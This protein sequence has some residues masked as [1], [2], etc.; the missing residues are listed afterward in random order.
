MTRLSSHASRWL[1]AAIA[2]P[3]VLWVLFW[4]PPLYFFLLVGLIGLG[5]WWEF[6]SVCFGHGKPGL[7]L[8]SV[9]GWML[10]V[11]GAALGGPLG[12]MAGLAGAGALGFLYFVFTFETTTQVIDQAGRFALGHAYLSL[13]LSFLILQFRLERGCWWILFTLVVTFIGDTAAFYVGKAFGRQ[14]LYPA[15]SPGKTWEGLLGGVL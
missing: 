14:L 10:A 3:V 11:T 15:V 5:A 9:M 1:V 2:A 13:F 7:R 12:L 6:L 4:A 8:V